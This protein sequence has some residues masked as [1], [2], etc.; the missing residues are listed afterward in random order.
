MR[1]QARA[2][3]PKPIFSRALPAGFTRDTATYSPSSAVK[4]KY[5]LR[6]NGIR[7]VENSIMLY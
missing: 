5:E 4:S 2:A 1:R 6:I 7:E 3:K